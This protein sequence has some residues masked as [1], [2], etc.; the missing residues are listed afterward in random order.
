MKIREAL[1][2]MGG[3]ST[4]A[5][6]PKPDG[7]PRLSGERSKRC[8]VE[9]TLPYLRYHDHRIVVEFTARRPV[10]KVYV[11]SADALLSTANRANFKERLVERV[12]RPIEHKKPGEENGE[13]AF[14][15]AFF[16][17][18]TTLNADQLHVTIDF[19]GDVAINKIEN[20]QS[21]RL[22]AILPDHSE[23]RSLIS[24]PIDFVIYTTG[25][26]LGAENL[27]LR[28]EIIAKALASRGKKVLYIPL[29]H[30]PNP[31]LIDLGHGV[32]INQ[33]SEHIFSRNVNTIVG[34]GAAKVF[35]CSS[36]CDTIAY[37]A[38]FIAKLKG[39]KVVYEVRDDMEAMTKLGFAKYY[40]ALL[41]ID[42][43]RLADIIVC[44]SEPLRQ[45]LIAWGI[46][47]SKIHVLPNG[48]SDEERRM[49][50]DIRRNPSRNRQ[51]RAV[52]FGHLFPSRF[53]YNLLAFLAE[54]FVEYDFALYGPGFAKG[55]QMPANV[56]H[57]GQV[58]HLEFFLRER[59]SDI[60]L[61][62]FVANN[63]TFSLSPLKLGQYYALGLKVVSSDIFQLRGAP[64]VF[65]DGSKSF[66]DNFAQAAA[67]KPT[68]Q[69]RN[70]VDEYMKKNSWSNVT[71]RIEEFLN[72]V[73]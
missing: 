14:R 11:T 70:A 36:K 48:C 73:P 57:E 17:R 68:L 41:E 64:L 71:S 10:F 24:N 20:E 49:H 54:T 66:F 33:I 43:A 47:S 62:P 39:L 28:S 69:D 26:P 51:K 67:Y 44:V 25:G 61:L 38:A 8:Q 42:I 40:D 29:G 30:V 5:Q 53:D 27:P 58:K 3:L 15:V 31:G 72:C 21:S 13:I 16:A 19:P 52:Y 63:M 46:D 59:D 9:V 56:R 45:K 4:K 60:G 37:Q 1:Q 32:G 12:H 50:D 22:S 18:P 23:V 34:G 2:L 55:R 7:A 35:M 65:S 6:P